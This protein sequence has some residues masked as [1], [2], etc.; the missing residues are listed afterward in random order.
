M[1]RNARE[2]I[3]PRGAGLP[4]PRAVPLV[5]EVRKMSTSA[6]NDLGIALYQRT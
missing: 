2:R 1:K 3:V 4:L 6:M 5:G